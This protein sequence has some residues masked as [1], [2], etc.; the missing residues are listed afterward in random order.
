MNFHLQLATFLTKAMDEQFRIGK[1]RFGLDPLLG[2]FPGFGDLIALMLS[3]YI[4]WIGMLLR[5]P[6]EKIGT[7]VKNV[8][9]DFLLG[10]IP[11]V[12]DVT[13]VIYKANSRNLRII[14][15]HIGVTIV[16]GSI[17]KTT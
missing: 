12:G 15:E 16:E 10:L 9:V 11:V 2:L 1:L 6:E 3:L 14:H 4:V 7:M 5:L 17:I 8:M 13:D